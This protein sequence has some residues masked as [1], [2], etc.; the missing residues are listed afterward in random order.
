MSKEYR[1]II[2]TLAEPTA[3]S[4]AKASATVVSAVAVNCKTMTSKIQNASAS[5]Q[6]TRA[7]QRPATAAAPTSM[8]YRPLGPSVSLPLSGASQGSHPQRIAWSTPPKE[9][10][11]STR[12]ATDKPPG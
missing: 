12:P 7:K 10:A 2:F 9:A 1:V 8:G 5:C 3:T 4:A 11:P 6:E